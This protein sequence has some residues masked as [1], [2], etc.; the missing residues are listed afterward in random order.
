MYHANSGFA[1][2]RFCM[3]LFGFGFCVWNFRPWVN[4]L[5]WENKVKTYSLVMNQ[6]ETQD[7]NQWREQVTE[8]AQNLRSRVQ[9]TASDFQQTAKEWQRRI[10]ETSRKAA[11]NADVYV[12]ENPW[13]VVASVAVACFALG[14]LLGRTRD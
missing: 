14:F 10:A 4:N 2:F 13:T 7:K 11:Q 8:G 1:Q 3:S 6:T 12:H 9:E 5:P